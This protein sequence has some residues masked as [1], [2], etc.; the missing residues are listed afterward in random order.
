M[1]ILVRNAGHPFGE[2]SF[3]TR[4]LR[5]GQIDGDRAF[6]ES[7]KSRGQAIFEQALESLF[8]YFYPNV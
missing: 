1:I 4:G 3:A 8:V 5:Y 2:M 7:C 6:R